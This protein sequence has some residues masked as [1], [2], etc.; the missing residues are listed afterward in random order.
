MKSCLHM[1][2]IY[3]FG[4]FGGKI[5]INELQRVMWYSNHIGVM[6]YLSHK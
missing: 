3:I 4:Q 5:I 2:A 6:W 1:H